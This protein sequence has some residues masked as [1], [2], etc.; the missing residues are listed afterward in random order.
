MCDYVVNI[1]NPEGELIAYK[2]ADNMKEA[3][4]FAKAHARS[5]HAGCYTQVRGKEVNGKPGALIFDS[6]DV[7]TAAQQ[8]VQGGL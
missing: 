5:L 6:R 7:V 8:Q 3:E 1:H 4:A 2:A